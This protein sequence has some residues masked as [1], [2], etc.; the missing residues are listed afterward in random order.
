MVIGTEYRA[1]HYCTWTANQNHSPQCAPLFR[2]RDCEAVAELFIL[3]E[4][5]IKL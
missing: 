3:I 1:P 2:L 5:A 4:K